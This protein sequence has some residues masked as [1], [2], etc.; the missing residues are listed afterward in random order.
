[1]LRIDRVKANGAW[2]YANDDEAT[3]KMAMAFWGF[4]LGE[5]DTW[6]LALDAHL[7]EPSGPFAE[8]L[9]EWRTKAISLHAAGNFDAAHGWRMALIATRQ[10]ITIFYSARSV[11]RGLNGIDDRM[12]LPPDD[13]ELDR[14]IQKLLDSGIAPRNVASTYAA[15]KGLTSGTQVRARRRKIASRKAKG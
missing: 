9:F 4:D 7:R 5:Y 2:K 3:F 6:L 14:D 15:R 13:Q 12:K 10:A 1:M 11:I 8:R